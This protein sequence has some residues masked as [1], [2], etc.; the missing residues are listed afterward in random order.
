MTLRD[1]TDAI[2]RF[3]RI[4]PEAQPPLRSD[5]AAGGLLP[6]RAFRYCEPIRTASAFG[7]YVFPPVNFSLMWDGT[8]TIWRM[9]NADEWHNLDAVQFPNFYD[10]LNSAC[11]AS[12]ANHVPPLIAACDEPGII[13]IWSGLFVRTKKDWSLLVRPPANLPRSTGYEPYEGIVETDLWFGPLFTNIRLT[14]TDI[15]IE[16]RTD[17]PFIQVQPLHRDSYKDAALSRYEFVDDV[18][19][20]E[21][22]DWADYERTII[23]PGVAH[24]RGQGVY[25]KKTRRRKK[26]EYAD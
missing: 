8:D 9:D 23:T 20:L 13:N 11:P 6:T 14:K 3:H 16:F 26:C 25:A 24:D 5:R 1:E 12:I 4:L 17:K 2:V 19:K 18:S 7:W 21:E 15:P 22:N 10:K